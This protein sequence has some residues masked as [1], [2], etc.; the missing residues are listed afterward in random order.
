MSEVTRMRLG[1][2]V[3]A[4]APLVLLVGMI[5]VPLFDPVERGP[6]FAAVAAG[7]PAR[8]Q[9]GWL[10]MATT[11]GMMI[12][13][14]FAI[15]GFLRSA[16]E[17]LWSVFML[18]L[19]TLAYVW[20]IFS[21]GEAFTLPLAIEAGA[22]GEALLGSELQVVNVYY[23]SFVPGLLSRICLLVGIWRSRVLSRPLT[24]ALIV[25][26][27]LFLFYFP[28][29]MDSPVASQYAP[30]LPAFF[31]AGVLSYHMWIRHPGVADRTSPA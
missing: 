10:L 13:G 22:S 30:F 7:N 31:T 17:N 11:N 21:L 8:W 14:L 26:E 24:W 4:I 2:A 25:S 19:G 23:L 29:T 15:R 16:G 6:A 28:L 18:P 3:V 27:V 12:L 9:W 1:A 5:V 20:A